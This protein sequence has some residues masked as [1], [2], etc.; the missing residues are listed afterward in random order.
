MSELGCHLSCCQFFFLSFCLFVFRYLCHFCLFFTPP[1]GGVESTSGNSVCHSAIA[2]IFPIY[3]LQIIPESCQTLHIIHHW[4]EDD[5]SHDD[6]NDK[7]TRKYKDN[8]KDKDKM[9]K[10]PITCYIFKKQGAQGFQICDAYNDKDI[11]QDKEKEK[12]K[13]KHKEKQKQKHKHKDKSAKKTQH[14]LYF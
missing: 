2:S 11:D 3:G 12:D 8:D 1:T 13:H 10:R 4:K 9:L 6:D 5:I 14:M 7:D